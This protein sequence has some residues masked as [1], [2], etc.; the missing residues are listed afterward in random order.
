MAERPI[1]FSASMVRALLEGRKTQTRRLAWT[2]RAHQ[3]GQ[4]P[5]PS[6]WHAVERGDLLWV[7]EAVQA[8]ED[9]E[10]FGIVRYLADGFETR[11]KDTPQAHEDWLRL[12]TYRADDLAAGGKTVPPIHMPRWAS[13]ITL[14]VTAAYIERL[15][16]MTNLCAWAEGT[17]DLRTIANG[18]DLRRCFADLWDQLHGRGAW[19]GNPEVVVMHFD[20][21]HGN[22]D[23]FKAP[24]ASSL[25][26]IR[27]VPQAHSARA[28]G[29]KP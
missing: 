7:R 17:P 6:P 2:D 28:E 29:D 12:Y 3:A 11:I 1:I 27:A 16:D 14:R 8:D 26:A 22:I 25:E 18:W 5:A 19:D 10:R 23:R 15:H 21:L 4:S 13:G 9:D 24:P 20:V